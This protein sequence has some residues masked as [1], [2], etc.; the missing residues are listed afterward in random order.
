ML[1]IK[2]QTAPRL[3]VNRNQQLLQLKPNIWEDNDDNDVD[4]GD[5]GVVHYCDGVNTRNI[6]RNAEQIQ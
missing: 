1:A 5:M 6:R 4:N 3:W 2:T